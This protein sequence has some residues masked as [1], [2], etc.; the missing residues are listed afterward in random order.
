LSCLLVAVR[1]RPPSSEWCIV[2]VDLPMHV[3]K[4]SSS[5]VLLY[6]YPST[7]AT[8]FDSQITVESLLHPRRDTAR[9]HSAR[10]SYRPPR[11]SLLACRRPGLLGALSPP[12]SLADNLLPSS[13]VGVRRRDANVF[14]PC[15]ADVHEVLRPIPCA[16]PSCLLTKPTT[17]DRRYH[18]FNI[19]IS[20]THNRESNYIMTFS[21]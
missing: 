20:S 19:S 21:I 13:H 2:V 17:K 18:I 4:A 6:T 10:R 12:S 1:R 5:L 16:S 14:L 15:H 9:V 3:T 7:P 8:M 11:R